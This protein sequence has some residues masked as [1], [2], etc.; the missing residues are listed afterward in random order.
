MGNLVVMEG[1]RC[2]NFCYIERRIVSG[3]VAMDITN[4]GKSILDTTA[5]VYEC[6][7]DD[8]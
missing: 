7:E 8:L 5:L 1:V 3:G 2:K 4:I 6:F